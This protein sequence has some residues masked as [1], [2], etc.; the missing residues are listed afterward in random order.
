MTKLNHLT[1]PQSA[2]SVILLI[3]LLPTRR[4][5]LPA[6]QDAKQLTKPNHLTLP[7]SVL[8]VILLICFHLML[9]LA[10]LYLYAHLDYPILFKQ[11]YVFNPFSD[12]LYTP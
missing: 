7:Q 8:S 5:V 12:V 1:I 10:L 3:Q 4:S 2:L 9:N 11:N 6:L